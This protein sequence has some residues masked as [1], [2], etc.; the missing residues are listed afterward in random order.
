[1]AALKIVQRG[2]VAVSAMNGSWA[3]AMGQT[4]FIP[5]TFE[6]Y[7]VDFDGNG[8]RNIWTSAADALASAANYLN[9]SGWQSGKTWGYEVKLP[10]GFNTRKSSERSLASWMKLGVRRVD[11]SGFPRPG[12]TASLYL[13]NG[14]NGPV[15]LT[16]KNFRVIKRYNSSNSYA[17]AVGNLSDRLRGGGPFVASWPAHEKP[18]T[19]EEGK[20]L[21]LL[22]TM[23]GFYDGDIDGDIGSGS[24][25]AIRDF[26][27][28]IGLNP[29]GVETRDLLQ[30]LEAAR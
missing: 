29:D 27:R 19:L 16:L 28:S 24:H 17:L 10:A 8:Q 5:T 12:D 23:H 22:L 7:A 4:Q 13:P 14:T 20:R 3:G 6:A 1:M 25:A 9:K 21:Q 2:D 11:G 15:F 26:Q 30:R 18:F